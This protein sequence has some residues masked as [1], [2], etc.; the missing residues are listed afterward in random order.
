MM[1]VTI[2]P[3]DAALWKTATY[4]GPALTAAAAGAAFKDDAQIVIESYELIPG[5]NVEKYKIQIDIP[6]ATIR[7]F[8]VIPSG[9]D[10]IEHDIE[11]VALRPV[12]AT[13]IMTIT[14]LSDQDVVN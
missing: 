5:A 13:P 11:I 6:Q 3:T 4:G 14:C 1:G 9:D 7:P 2:R 12:P 8:E 10:I